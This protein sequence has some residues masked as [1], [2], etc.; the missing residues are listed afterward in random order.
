MKHKRVRIAIGVLTAFIALTAI[1]G[2]I[3]LL[4]GTYQDGILIEAGGEPSFRWSGYET[5]RSAITPFPR[6]S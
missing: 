6:S 5:R 2:G 4:A 1:G 3:A